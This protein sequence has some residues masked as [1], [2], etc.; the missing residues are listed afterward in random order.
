M[1]GLTPQR[2][3]AVIDIGSNSVRLVIYR[4]VGTAM[5]PHFN[6]KVMAGLGKGLNETGHL[7][8][9]GYVAAIGA[10]KRYTAILQALGVSDVQCVATAAVREAEDGPK[11]GNEANKIL[12][13]PVRVLS[14]ADEARLSCL[15]VMAGIHEPR[16]VMGDLGGSSLEFCQITGK[17]PK[18]GETHKLGPFN[19]QDLS[20]AESR[21]IIRKSLK[22]SGVLGA[23][24]GRFYA[25]GGAWRA[26]AKMHMTLG[27]Y[28]LHALHGH[29][30]SALEVENIIQSIETGGEGLHA[31]I[32]SVTGRRGWAVAHAARV[33]KEIFDLG[34]F[35][36]MVVSAYGVR[37]GV[38]AEIGGGEGDPLI[39]GISASAHLDET[40]YAFGA[41]LHRFVRDVLTEPAQLFEVDRPQ[42]RIDLAACMLA[43]S[44][45]RLHPDHR[46]D[47]AYELAL[48]GP[49]ATA[50]HAERAFIAMAVGCRYYK[51]FKRPAL[52][53]VLMPQ[54]MADRAR[55]L[56]A[57]M[58]LGGV[59]SGRSA[60]NLEF[61]SLQK[62]DS[63][64]TMH[65][66]AGA[67]AMV[68]ETV[69]TRLAKSASLM[70]LE[71]EIVIG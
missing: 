53:R 69:R 39:D 60:P 62:S 3:T 11:F 19:F 15:G 8:T 51:R 20:E 66:Q 28:P 54:P 24:G 16:G 2:R 13:V 48:R 55:I 68:S 52:H 26:L 56:G 31:R 41:A 5:L 22:S 57:L 44:G 29:R 59:F 34:G 37:E 38:L 43:D 49:Y 36:E 6:E 50:S 33:L 30:M 27:D 17:K 25:V 18:K 12:G 7:S 71:P 58:R 70:G 14:G 9:K 46:A 4:R 67:E 1:T 23:N 63:M 45:A 32:K 21:K 65:V 35:E 10:L 47:L 42:A 61:A 40:Q 64:L